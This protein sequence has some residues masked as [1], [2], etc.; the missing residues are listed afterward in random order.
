MRGVGTAEIIQIKKGKRLALRGR[1]LTG[2][3][4]NELTFEKRLR[5]F[6]TFQTLDF[7]LFRQIWTLN[8]R[9]VAIYIFVFTSISFCSFSDAINWPESDVICISQ[10]LHH[11]KVVVAFEL[12]LK[13]IIFSQCSTMGHRRAKVIRKKYIWKLWWQTVEKDILKLAKAC[14]HCIVTRTGE[15]VPNELFQP[16]HGDL[17]SDFL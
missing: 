17:Q 4:L 7:I 9:T 14:Q 8:I 6:Q 12:K 2:A 10:A 11:L 1:E 16:L 15:N 13:S 5:N 3:C